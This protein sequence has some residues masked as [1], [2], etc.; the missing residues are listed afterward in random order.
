MGKIRPVRGL[1]TS[2]GAPLAANNGVDALL[3][4][5]DTMR[6]EAAASAATAAVAVSAGIASHIASGDPHTQYLDSTRGPYSSATASGLAT[7]AVP[8]A[9]S[10]VYLRGYSNEGRGGAWYDRLASAP[11]PAKAWHFQ[12]SDGAWWELGET[13]VT[14][15]MFG[16]NGDYDLVSATTDN[17]T[18][19]AEAIGAALEYLKTRGGGTLHL[20]GNRVYRVNSRT[21]VSGLRNVRITGPGSIFRWDAGS[22]INV[23]KFLN[24]SDVIIDGITFRSLY[25]GFVGG[26]TGDVSVIELDSAN[27][28]T[29]N[30]RFTIRGNYF[31]GFRHSAVLLRGTKRTDGGMANLSINI[32]GNNFRRGCF[33]VFVYKNAQQITVADNFFTETNG[34]VIFDTRAQSDS[35]TTFFQI[36]SCTIRG[37]I[38]KN[39]GGGTHN[40]ECRGILL[41]GGCQ[42]IVV[43]ENIV[44]GLTTSQGA[45]TGTCVAYYVT[46]DWGGQPGANIS[47][48]GNVARGVRV[49]G[50]TFNGTGMACVVD[51]GFTGVSVTNNKFTNIDRGAQLSNESEW[52][53]AGNML[54]DC[55]ITAATYP[56]RIVYASASGLLKRVE[57]NTF[58]KGTGTSAYSILLDANCSGIHFEP[59]HAS[60]FSTGKLFVGSGASEI[61]YGMLTIGSGSLS[62]AGG[63]AASESLVTLG[64]ITIA[65]AAVSDL[66]VITTN[67]SGVFR[68]CA[69][70]GVVTSANTVNLTVYNSTG[71]AKTLPAATF[72][73]LVLRRA[74]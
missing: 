16:G 44:D 73:A 34:G 56:L 4:Q 63:S 60:G 37:N 36:K 18:N 23:F 74:P 47:V 32:T 43:S 15:E 39:I 25:D 55:G 28:G 53:F 52:T 67:N 9:V 38:L 65:G 66:V 62:Y 57:G 7:L 59:N 17:G 6:D 51:A 48:L 50:A 33:G 69:V 42:D 54:V 58:V 27:D 21:D 26:S 49:A 22:V 14:P 20:P 35:D 45:A 5:I 71:A 11:S 13:T 1:H 72:T 8:L 12:S 46:K 30:E 64:T 19:N 10:R 2:I 40:I 41:K 68:E 29:V 31:I 24:S 70:Y 3:E 61:T